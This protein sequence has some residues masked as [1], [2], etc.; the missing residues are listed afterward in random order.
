MSHPRQLLSVTKVAASF[1]LV[2]SGSLLAACQ[3]AYSEPSMLDDE[4]VDEPSPPSG[5]LDERQQLARSGQY[6]RAP[7]A[8]VM[9][10][11]TAEQLVAAMDLPGLFV[12]GVTLQGPDV[13]ASVFDHW[14]VIEPRRGEQLAVLSTGVID[15]IPEPG[16]DMGS[17]GTEGDE[18]TLQIDLEIPEGFNRLSFDYNFLSAESP[19]YVGSLY[20]DTFTATLI[21]PDGVEHEIALASVNSS[22]F[23]DASADRAGGTQFDIFTPDP[24]GVDVQFIGGLPDAGITDFQPV[25]IELPSTGSWSLVFNIHDQGDGLF[26]SSVIID[27]LRIR[28]MEWLSL[29]PLPPAPPAQFNEPQLVATDGAII[30]DPALLV[31]AG[32]RVR[33]IAADGVTQILLRTR[34]PGPGV[35]EYSLVGGT[36]PADGSVAPLNGAPG[37][38]VAAATVE[39]APG[40]FYAFATYTAPADFDRGTDGE[41]ASRTVELRAQFTPDD[42]QESAFEDVQTLV[43]ERPPVV[44]VHGLWGSSPQWTLPLLDDPRLSVY[45]ANYDSTVHLADS[46][47]VVPAGSILA[48]RLGQQAEQIAGSQVDLVGH[49]IGGLLARRYLDDRANVGA[50]NFGQG[51]VHKLITLNTPHLGSDLATAGMEMLGSP[52]LAV[53]QLTGIR[54]LMRIQGAPLPPDGGALDDIGVG[55]PLFD[56]LGAAAVPSHAIIGFGG[57]LIP[58]TQVDPN[59]LT[60]PAWTATGGNMLYSMIERYHP[61][62]NDLEQT[63][64]ARSAFIFGDDSQVFFGDHDM[65][66]T[67]TSQQGGIELAATTELESHY[68]DDNDYEFGSMHFDLM[69]SAAYSARIVELLGEPQG[70]AAFGTFPAPN[71]AVPLAPAGDPAAAGA[72]A[73]PALPS[74]LN[75]E[76]NGL[77]ILSPAPGAEVTPGGTVTV[78]VAPDPGLDVVVLGVVTQ[79]AARVIEEPVFPLSVEMPVPPGVVGDLEIIAFGISATGDFLISSITEVGAEAA[80]SLLHVHIVDRD[81]YLFGIGDARS[82][83]VL[84]LYDDGIERDITSA[85]A[86]TEYLTS[87]PG[88]FTVMDDGTLVATGLG[89]ATLVA[90]NADVQDSVTVE[91]RPGFTAGFELVTDWGQGYCASLRVSNGSPQAT[92][93]WEVTLD[94]GDS[95]LTEN[96]DSVFSGGTGIVSVGPEHDWQFAV[97]SG[98]TKGYT[99]FCALRGP[100]GQV[101]PTIV[102]ATAT[103]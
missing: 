70:G 2:G 49:G 20:N 53:Y 98:M 17:G 46:D 95:T 62:L 80:A 79:S 90:R 84:G 22:A 7:G 35:V 87:N 99:G 15:T 50:A 54:T 40:E 103:F 21:D 27:N 45:R 77:T 102:D 11:A 89:K 32:Q 12:S 96:W 52:L 8:G 42:P 23:F 6:L 82:V 3:G 4:P 65:F 75:V 66:A 74:A 101:L 92:T 55:Q 61:T 41:L 85:S 88:I 31:Q 100:T 30:D 5:E 1:F 56:E 76:P 13:S 94:L 68:V 16:T 39:A 67:M 37:D 33:G 60:N 86:G 97:P 63:D 44:L 36:S 51:H 58:H 29:N 57:P 71:D 18:V 10:P 78:S 64:P 38:L 34:V 24:S 26:D 81:P 48:A 72:S 43:I 83:D 19:D 47:D 59:G 91:V 69:R 14:G 93:D 73:P 25:D 9:A 28:A